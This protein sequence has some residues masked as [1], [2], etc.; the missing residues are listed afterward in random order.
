MFPAPSA[1]HCKQVM[2]GFL[3]EIMSIIGYF[4]FRLLATEGVSNSL[5]IGVPTT[6]LQVYVV[7]SP[8]HLLSVR[9]VLAR[10]SRVEPLSPTFAVASLHTRTEWFR[11]N[12]SAQTETD[13]GKES[14]RP[15]LDCSST[16]LRSPSILF[17]VRRMSRSRARRSFSTR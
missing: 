10:W 13:R 14:P 6:T 2:P 11:Y 17:F 8:G 12:R 1:T 15:R 3:G 16:A 7:L 4:C 9:Q 5:A